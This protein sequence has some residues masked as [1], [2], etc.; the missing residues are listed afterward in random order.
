MFWI[1]KKNFIFAQ[2]L[3]ICYLFKLLCEDNVYGFEK[4]NICM[5]RL[6]GI[7]KN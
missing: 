5:A 4:Q 1:F 6:T 7:V 3:G 2:F